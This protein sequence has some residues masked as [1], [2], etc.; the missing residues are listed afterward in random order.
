VDPGGE[1]ENQ[2]RD[3]HR[4]PSPPGNPLPGFMEATQECVEDA[5]VG[6]RNTGAG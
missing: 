2:G 1:G 3:Q 6:G 5:Q 4:H